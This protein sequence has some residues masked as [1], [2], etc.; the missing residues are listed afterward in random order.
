MDIFG[1]S[2]FKILTEENVSMT[3]VSGSGKAEG[4][5]GSLDDVFEQWNDALK[6]WHSTLAQLEDSLKIW[7]DIPEQDRTSDLEQWAN[8]QK[9]WAVVF[10]RWKDVSRAEGIF[11]RH[12]GDKKLDDASDQ[13]VEAFLKDKGDISK[14]LDIVFKQLSNVFQWWSYVLVDGLTDISRQWDNTS[15]QVCNDVTG[16][17]RSSV[18]QQWVNTFARWE[19]VSDRWNNIHKS[20]KCVLNNKE[21]LFREDYSIDPDWCDNPVDE[22]KQQ[23]DDIKWWVSVSN[24]WVSVSSKWGSVSRE[25]I[26]ALKE[27]SDAFERE[28]D[29]VKRW[30][31]EHMGEIEFIEQY[32]INVLK[33][34]IEDLEWWTDALKQYPIDALK[35]WAD[36]SEQ[37]VNI[38]EQWVGICESY[39]HDVHGE[40]SLRYAKWI[41]IDYSNK[42]N[43]DCFDEGEEQ[44]DDEREDWEDISKEKLERN[45]KKAGEELWNCIVGEM[46]CHLKWSKDHEGLSLNKGVSVSMRDRMGI[47]EK[48]KICEDILDREIL[49]ALRDEKTD[50]EL[51]G[52]YEEERKGLLSSIM[53]GTAS[54][55]LIES[56]ADVFANDILY[57]L[58]GGAAGSE[59]SGAYEKG[60][61]SL[62]DSL[63]SSTVDPK[64]TKACG[65]VLRSRVAY[66]EVVTAKGLPFVI[67]ANAVDGRSGECCE[68]SID[69]R[70]YWPTQN[71]I[72]NLESTKFYEVAV[73]RLRDFF[74]DETVHQNAKKGC[75]ESLVWGLCIEHD[76]I[77]GRQSRKTN[78]GAVKRLQDFLMG[79]TDNQELVK[80]FKD[81]YVAEVMTFLYANNWVNGDH[82]TEEALE[83]IRQHDRI[84]YYKLNS[85]ESEAEAIRELLR[86]EVLAS[87]KNGTATS[88]L[89]EAYKNV[90]RSLH[91]SLT[92]GTANEVMPSALVPFV[93]GGVDSELG[94]SS[95]RW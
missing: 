77:S 37:W 43:N 12:I 79:S 49:K 65:Y 14:Q 60:V 34:W 78:K 32:R 53:S 67:S 87:M 69:K 20:W 35:Q 46:L 21:R 71:E 25:T 50:P 56:C 51:T 81:F 64:L 18:I 84:E 13:R 42:D 72:D 2:L 92:N 47:P 44:Y 33:Q 28:Y 57:C 24:R 40:R 93:S 4:N 59:L 36:A 62:R 19:D 3:Q 8:T 88:N 76:E 22:L 73:E 16:Q 30:L 94:R 75:E 5:R 48:V 68:V 95:T 23:T 17:E 54:Q 15:K 83:L 31:G 74:K 27:W 26:D 85:M 10:E 61:K 86:A 7:N 89:V 1:R 91:T 66:Q 63:I 80:I 41:D 58:R 90:T 52:Y 39:R 70:S 38:S 6:Q 55:E 45:Y 29:I 82:V 11:I 9:K